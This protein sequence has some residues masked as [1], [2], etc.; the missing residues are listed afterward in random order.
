[1]SHSQ[2]TRKDSA[3]DPAAPGSPAP[4]PKYCSCS[5]EELIALQIEAWA[6]GAACAKT[7]SSHALRDFATIEQR[8]EAAC[9]EALQQY[10]P[11]ELARFRDV[12][13][14]AWVGGYCAARGTTG[15]TS[16][17]QGAC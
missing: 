4:V 11:L 9:D 6:Q 3:P 17:V 8:A 16:S 15:N 10:V 1:M 12:F 5:H 14:L 13:T 7:D 2:D